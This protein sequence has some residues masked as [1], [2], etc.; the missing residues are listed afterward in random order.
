M[1][2]L[3]VDPPP[4]VAVVHYWWLANRGGEHF[5]AAL[6]KLFPDADLYVQVC[7]EA[8]VRRT[9]GPGFRGRI[10]QGFVS[11]LP[12]AQKHYQK[13]LPLM[14]L[15]MEQWDLT[16]YDLVISCESGPAKGVVTRP[17][18][19]HVC[20]VHTPM[21][22]LWDQYHAYK[23]TAPAPVRWLWPLVAHWLR[24]WDRH[25][26]DRVDLFLAN[27]AFVAARVRKYWRREARVLYSPASVHAFG[28]REP[29]GDHYLVLGQLARYKR[30]DL[31]VRACNRLGLPL[32][33]IGEGEQMDELRRIAGPT[34]QLLGRQ[35]F[36]VVRRQLQ[37]C[38]ALLFPGI[39]DFGLVPVEAQAAGAPV[40]AYGEG[41]AVETVLDGV[42]GRLVPEQTVEA[43]AEAILEIESG[44]LVVDPQAARAQ[45]LRFSP[46]LFEAE[47]LQV[48]GAAYAAHRVGCVPPANPRP[49]PIM[50]P[51]ERPSAA[52]RSM[53]PPAAAPAHMH[54][55][56]AD[57]LR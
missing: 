30:A 37:T 48:L 26:A 56:N 1:Q 2:A 8:L 4:K 10:V 33:V 21:R 13:Y 38:R 28:A 23:A 5:A 42:T 46:E 7:D 36:D 14:P 32:V 53:P 44:R 3:P 29:R 51:G 12:G 57:M 9:L 15:A 18:A 34:V 11:R 49:A 43:F 19:L 40:I 31:A 17:D 20:Y 39:E 27:S 45:A 25:S 52:P 16:G 35:P 47:L 50:P 54:P 55:Q 24:V 6:L 22:Y 41:G